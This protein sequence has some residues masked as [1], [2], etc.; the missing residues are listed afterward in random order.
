MKTKEEIAATREDLQR[1]LREML[2]PFFYTDEQRS[3]I[4]GWITAL[5]WVLDIPNNDKPKT[6]PK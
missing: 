5:G 3:K 6:K 2:N 1:R 4:Q